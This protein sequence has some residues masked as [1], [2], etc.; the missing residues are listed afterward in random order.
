MLI[1]K[2]GGNHVSRLR[3][4]SPWR[5][6]YEHVVVCS[7]QY[8]VFYETNIKK[9]KLLLGRMFNTF[10]INLVL[11]FEQRLVPQVVLYGFDLFFVWS[12]TLSIVNR[13]FMVL[14]DHFLSLASWL[15]LNKKNRDILKM[16]LQLSASKH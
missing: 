11:L 4:L 16:I 7:K 10:R 2:S 13:F 8:I 3:V 6:F 5:T 15:W 1:L 12:I 9:L 14:E